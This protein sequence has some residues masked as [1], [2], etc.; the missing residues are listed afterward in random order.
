MDKWQAGRGGGGGGTEAAEADAG[1]AQVFG[2]G[3]ASGLAA[4]SLVALTSS[5]AGR[6]TSP[7]GSL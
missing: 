7:G 6:M 4:V 3:F 1:A 5:L 2:M